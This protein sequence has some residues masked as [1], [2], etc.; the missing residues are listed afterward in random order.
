MS[1]SVDLR[2]RAV[3]YY[4]TVPMKMDTKTLGPPRCMDSGIKGTPQRVDTF[5]WEDL[6]V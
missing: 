1:K 5:M 2:L 6:V 4:S 3:N